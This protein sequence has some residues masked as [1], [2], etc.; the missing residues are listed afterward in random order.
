M[1]PKLLADAMKSHKWAESISD[2]EFS[3]ALDFLQAFTI[4]QA[5]EESAS[6]LS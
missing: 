6:Q 1:K 3:E 4:H 5:L 2:L